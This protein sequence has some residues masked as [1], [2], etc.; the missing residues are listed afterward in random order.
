MTVCT[1]LELCSRPGLSL[2]DSFGPECVNI[3]FGV[4]VRDKRLS[5]VTSVSALSINSCLHEI[6][7]QRGAARGVAASRC[8]NR[9]TDGRKGF[10]QMGVVATCLPAPIGPSITPR[11]GFSWLKMSISRFARTCVCH[12]RLEPAR[13]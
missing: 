13:N 12:H 5:C 10:F 2:R 11:N 9:E 7:T 1:T 4:S 3:Q 8:A 6:L